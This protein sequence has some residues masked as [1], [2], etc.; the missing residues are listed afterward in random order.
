MMF[1]YV[2]TVYVSSDPGTH[3][4]RIRFT[5]QNRMWQEG[6]TT[7]STKGS[8]NDDFLCLTYGDE[9]LGVVFNMRNM[10]RQ[11]GLI[12]KASTDRRNDHGRI[13]RKSSEFVQVLLR[14]VRGA[15]RGSVASSTGT[16]TAWVLEVSG[17]LP[18]RVWKGNRLTPFP[19]LIL[20]VELPN[21]NNWTN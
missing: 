5:F 6:P 13:R 9:L 16:L 1:I 18:V 3:I 20:V 8:P 21:T 2:I 14:S 7:K 4:V 12:I 19:K 17:R 15:G 11:G 10:R